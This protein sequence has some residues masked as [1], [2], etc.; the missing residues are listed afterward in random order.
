MRLMTVAYVVSMLAI[1]GSA[2]AQ[3]GSGTSP[4]P[5]SAGQ[6]QAT[7]PSA[8]EAGQRGGEAAGAVLLC[9][10]LRLTRQAGDLRS[11]FQGAELAEFDKQATRVLQAWQKAITCANAGGPNPCRISLQRNCMM[12][13]Q[14]IGPQGSALPGLL[15]P[16]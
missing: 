9:D 13:L 11:R 6:E 7:A 4:A 12:A 10:R 16:K 3:S 14:E 5:A 1:A 2:A 8:T 15:E